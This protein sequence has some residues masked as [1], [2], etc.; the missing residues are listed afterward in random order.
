MLHILFFMLFISKDIIV[1]KK[2]S[3]MFPKDFKFLEVNYYWQK[4]IEHAS[5]ISNLL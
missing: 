2:N 5:I 1:P 4:V 3:K